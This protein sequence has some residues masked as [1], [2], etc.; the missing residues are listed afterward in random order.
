MW[1]AREI[2]VVSDVILVV[3]VVVCGVCLC[4][5]LGLQ[6]LVELLVEGPEPDVV[7][8][9]LGDQVGHRLHSLLLVHLKQVKHNPCL[10]VFSSCST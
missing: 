4:L 8:V 6:L 10:A 2:N 1:D 9:V 5:D 3:S 7:G